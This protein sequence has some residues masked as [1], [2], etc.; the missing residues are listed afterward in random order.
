MNF[1]KCELGCFEQLFHISLP[2]KSIDSP[3]P[4]SL[5]TIRIT[6]I[7]ITTLLSSRDSFR[8]LLSMYSLIRQV[9]VLSHSA[10]TSGVAQVSTCISV[11]EA[12]VVPRMLNRDGSSPNDA[13]DGDAFVDAVMSHRCQHPGRL[14]LRVHS[15]CD[16]ICYL[17]VVV[18]GHIHVGR[19]YYS[20]TV[21][22]TRRPVQLTLG[23]V[24]LRGQTSMDC[25]KCWVPL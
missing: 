21:F 20:S 25:R 23:T 7:I 22:A 13:R 8:S 10:F 19:H 24:G 16:N 1:E 5:Y 12:K 17:A 11:V 3:I 9:T 6:L 2:S 18:S 4:L 15:M 14:V